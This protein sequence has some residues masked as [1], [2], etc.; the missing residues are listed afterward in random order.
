MVLICGLILVFISFGSA[1]HGLHESYAK[2]FGIRLK[3]N[4]LVLGSQG[5]ICYNIGDFIKKAR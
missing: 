4:E 5:N 3:Y 2:L 1:I